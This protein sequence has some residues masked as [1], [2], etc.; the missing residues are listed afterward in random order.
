MLH[1]S[2]GRFASPYPEPRGKPIQFRLPKSMDESM[3]AA[4]A[5]SLGK[6]VS[7]VSTYDIRMWIEGAIQQRLHSKVIR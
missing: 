7:E 2:T 4:V 1:D 3:R 6:P 5:R